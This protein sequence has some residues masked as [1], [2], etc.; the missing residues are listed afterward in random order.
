MSDDEKENEVPSGF[1][2]KKELYKKKKL[3]VKVKAIKVIKIS[4]LFDY[5]ES[6]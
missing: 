6:E 1:L 2:Q 4:N 3:K 5:K